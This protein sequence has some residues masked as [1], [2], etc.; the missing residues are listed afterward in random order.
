MHAML[1]ALSLLALCSAAAAP[2]QDRGDT[3]ARVVLPGISFTRALNKAAE[4]T[5]V[6]GG[7]LVMT[8]NAKT[9]N[10]IEPDGSL[11]N[12]SAPVLLAEIDNRKPFTL[13]AR[14]TPELVETYDAGA[15][16]VWAKPDLWLKMAME[17]DERGLA[18][19]VSVRTSGTSDDNNHDVIAA[20][21]VHMKISSDTRTV[22]FYYSIDALNW[23]L[24]RL[25]R[26]DYPARLWLGVSA[27]SP[28][29]KG[30]TAVFEEVALR[31]ES[32]A[33]F[34]MGK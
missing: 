23:Q 3:A 15:L 6:E 17:R 16:Y 5:R 18:R 1:P 13:S 31:D 33:D 14:V 7:R 28:L 11:A 32:I 29:G 9:D 19:M 34:R 22:G 27:Q 12:N 8:S 24:I 26:N 20:K 4:G 25:F 30:Q 21:S 10:F 2:A